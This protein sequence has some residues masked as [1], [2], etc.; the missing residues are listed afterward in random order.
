MHRCEDTVPCP[1]FKVFT[2]MRETHEEMPEPPDATES[3]VNQQT[4]GTVH[5]VWWGEAG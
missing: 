3:I 2:S 1:P 5:E 4:K